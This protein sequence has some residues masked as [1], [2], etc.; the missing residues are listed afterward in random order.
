ML[1]TEVQRCRQWATI[2][3]PEGSS[4]QKKKKK[5]DSDQIA[6]V[7]NWWFFSVFNLFSFAWKSRARLS[8]EQEAVIDS[9]T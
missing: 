6:E 7:N 5:K 2:I 9:A 8:L 3:W 1:R 4:G